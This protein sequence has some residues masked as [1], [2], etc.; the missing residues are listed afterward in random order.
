MLN[1]H[2]FRAVYMCVGVCVFILLLRFLFTNAQ[3]KA[4]NWLGEKKNVYLSQ[5]NID[6]SSVIALVN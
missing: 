5:Q 2:D 4:K 1:Y 6:C 3:I